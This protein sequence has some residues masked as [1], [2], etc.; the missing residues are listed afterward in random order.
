M[1]DPSDD[2]RE[3]QHAGAADVGADGL[4]PGIDTFLRSSTL[5]KHAAYFLVHSPR[6]PSVS[7]Q[8]L[9]D[10]GMTEGNSTT[11]RRASESTGPVRESAV[12]QVIIL[13]ASID[14]V[15]FQG[16]FSNP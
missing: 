10:R 12:K 16:D 3:F 1:E 15:E 5:S 13:R 11:R 6:F 4:P 2:P 9:M 8:G 14:Y 7:L